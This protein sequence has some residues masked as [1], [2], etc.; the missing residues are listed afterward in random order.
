MCCAC[1]VSSST[2]LFVSSWMY[3]PCSPASPAPPNQS[4]APPTPNNHYPTSPECAQPLLNQPPTS[5]SPL[6]DVSPPIE[7]PHKKW[8]LNMTDAMPSTMQPSHTMVTKAKVGTSRPKEL[9]EYQVY[10]YTKHPLKA[11][12]PQQLPSEPTFYS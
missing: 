2:S 12:Q 7:Q 10:Y 11:I 1:E 4:L 9:K 3:Q 6:A 5:P 8:F